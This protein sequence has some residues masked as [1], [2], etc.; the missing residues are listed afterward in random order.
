MNKNRSL[1]WTLL[2]P[3]LFAVPCNLAAQQPEPVTL[4]QAVDLALKSSREVALAQARYNVAENTAKLN[5]S[6]FR[7]NLTVG[8][9]AA[10]A[11]GFPQTP[12]GTA[13]S[14]V[15]LSYVQTLFNPSLRGHA[16]AATER[17]EAQRLELEKTRN[18]VMLQAGTAYLELGKVH[19]SLDL[20]LSQRQSSARIL[21]FTKARISE[22]LELPIEAT[23]AE[24]AGARLEQSIVQLESRETVLEHRL[25]ELL[26]FPV[27]RRIEVETPT[28]PVDATLRE[29]DLVDRALT[30][31]L[32]VKQAEFER[33]AREHLETGEAGMKWPTV[34]LFGQYGLFAKYNNYTDYFKTFQRNNFTVGVQVRIPIVNAQHSASVSLARSEL[35]A[36]ELE[37]KSKR[38][39]V[40]REVGRQYQQLR[41]LD[42]AHEVARLELKLA[43]EN[44]QILQVR[45]E[46]GR[47]NLRDVEQARLDENEKWVAFLN[48]D[49]DRKKAQLDLMNMTGDLQQLFR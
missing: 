10:Y 29:S 27:D 23:R 42:A 38:G 32:D 18:S 21:T 14:I 48:R 36:S 3:A 1:T 24:L 13:P 47:A 30:T 15:D 6:A 4:K 37:L 5:G 44:L 20:M 11:Y 39:S 2:L 45:F 34:D 49:Y 16:F 26:G 35:A 19:Q 7:P 22:G 9:G 31:N 17:A 46:E 40:E 8:S 25:A 33:R 12:G 43:Q 41:E 28:F